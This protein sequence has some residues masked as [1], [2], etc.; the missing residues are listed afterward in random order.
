MRNKI[1]TFERLWAEADEADN[2]MDAVPE[3]E[4]QDYA[5]AWAL[6]VTYSI[7]DHRRELLQELTGLLK[8]RLGKFEK[9][10]L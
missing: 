7:A 3:D 4:Q 2:G 9:S 8:Q 1:S 5:E 6:N 10:S